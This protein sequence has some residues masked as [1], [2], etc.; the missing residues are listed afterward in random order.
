MSWFWTVETETCSNC[1]I[2]DARLCWT[3]IKDL[4]WTQKFSAVQPIVWS[5]CQLSYTAS[6]DFLHIKLTEPIALVNKYTAATDRC[7]MYRPTLHCPKRNAF[8]SIRFSYIPPSCDP[9]ILIAR[10]L[11][12]IITWQLPPATYTFRCFH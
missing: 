4:C 5:L 12:E 9:P 6:H 3:D 2:N 8:P 10:I 7:H 1:K 11:V